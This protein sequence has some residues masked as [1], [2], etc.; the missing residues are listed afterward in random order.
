MKT[1]K[2]IA[3]IFALSVM[4]I[5]CDTSTRHNTQTSGFAHGILGSEIDEYDNEEDYNEIESAV[6][7]SDDAWISTSPNATAYHIYDDCEALLHTVYDIEYID[8]EDAELMGRH[9]C[10][11]CAERKYCEDHGIPYSFEW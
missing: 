6:E 1:L 4:S 11:Y 9:L 8:I 10:H 3:I 7:D 5:G 2:I